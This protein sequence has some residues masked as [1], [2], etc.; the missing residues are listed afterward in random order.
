MTRG[1]DSGEAWAVGMAALV[2]L[3]ITFGAPHV[4]TVGLKLIAADLG[5]QR[6]VPAGAQAMAWFGIGVGGLLMGLVAERIGVRL[7]VF[8]G[9][10]MVA[11]GLMLSSGG[12][13]WQ[14]YLGHAVF[15]GLIGNGAINA[16]IY[17]YI[18]RWFEKKRGSAI[19]LIASGQ[20]VAGAVWPSLFER[21]IAAWGWRQTMLAFG[22]LVAASAAPLALLML[23]PP[24]AVAPQTAAEA[25]RGGAG[26]GGQAD[27]VLGLRPNLLFAMLCAASFLCCIPM[28]MPSAHLVAFC[29]DL[30]LGQ[31]K[32]AAM[33]SLLLVCAFAARQ[34]WG[35]LSDTIGGVPTLVICSAAQALAVT[36]F[37]VTQDEAGLFF[38][39]AAFGL[40]FSGLIPAY[41][42]TTR[43][44]F[45]ASEAAWRM[46]TLLLTG[47]VGM[48]TGGWLA[49]A[50]Y[51]QAG[52]YWPAFATGL[53]A[54]ILNFIILAEVLVAWRRTEQRRALA[55]PKP[56]PAE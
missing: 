32:G 20:Y 24:P 38:V 16:P 40:G 30:G 5:G 33:L 29:G 51:D 23:K 4:V 17:V 12:E 44:L 55:T 35:W 8:T 54:N 56:A 3:S 45:P 14:I 21:A 13:V 7:T 41:L 48:A 18:S 39:A 15:I 9:T 46:P 26:T 1:V 27:R 50:I 6:S 25:A 36:G 2:I 47:T 53:A 42:M 19:A 34:F 43:N 22:L 31:A 28:A 52:S 37:L 49:G 10:V 11:A